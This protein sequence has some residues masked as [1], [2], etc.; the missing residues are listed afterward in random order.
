M[1]RRIAGALSALL[2]PM[3]GVAAAEPGAVWADRLELT[4]ESVDRQLLVQTELGFQLLLNDHDGLTLSGPPAAIGVT[5]ATLIRRILGDAVESFGPALRVQPENAQLAAQLGL[6]RSYIVRLAP[7]V[8]ADD[9]AALLRSLGAGIRSAART[10]RAITHAGPG[11]TGGPGDPPQ[12]SDP[13]IPNDPGFKDQF[14]LRNRGQIVGGQAGTAGSD[15]NVLDA[16]GW[17]LDLHEITVAVIDSGVS[18]S[19]PDLQDALLTGANMFCVPQSG[20]FDQSDDDGSSHGT[21]VA[22]IIGAAKNNGTGVAGIASGVRILPVK[23]L[24]ALGIGI[25][26]ITGNGIIWATDQGADVIS[27]SIGHSAPNGFLAD[28]VEYAHQSGVVIV[29]SS[30]NIP[31]DPIAYPAAYESTIAVGATD[32]TDQPASFMS[33]GPGLTVV[34]PGIDIYSTWDSYAGPGPDT[35]HALSGTSQACPQVAGVA[36]LILAA[37]PTLTPDEV[38]AAITMTARDLGA[39]GWDTQYGH[40]VIDA[41]AAIRYAA[42]PA[43]IAGSAGM[44]ADGVVDAHDLAAYLRLY[45]DQDPHADI[46]SDQGDLSG[47]GSVDGADFGTFIDQFDSGCEP[48]IAPQ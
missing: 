46:A 16:W 9:A 14:A 34:A 17:G 5:E 35:V 11:G 26:E 41:V 47:D 12:P 32:N 45:F 31:S 48:D 22:G 2:I 4:A 21:H 30:G 42:C 43:D 39:P 15:I 36:A 8:D 18:R 33:T 3:M 24:N 7:G 6:D 29:A 10:S 37:H 40:G 19:H 13:N 28:A 38:R 20:C 27:I 23:V 44:G 25:P 1:R